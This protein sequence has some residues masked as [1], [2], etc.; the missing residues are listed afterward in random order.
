M[1]WLSGPLL[2]LSLG[3]VYAQTSGD[4]I[5]VRIVKYDGLKDIVL[6]NRGKVVIVDFW[7]TT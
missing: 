4:A 1:R 6:K 2:A 5:N 7:F 3:A